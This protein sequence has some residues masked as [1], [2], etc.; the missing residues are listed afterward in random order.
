MAPKN[1]GAGSAID[2]TKAWTTTALFCYASGSSTDN[3]DCQTNNLY[4]GTTLV[5][6][7]STTASEAI[8]VG[9]V[10]TADIKARMVAGGELSSAYA[11]GLASAYAGVDGLTTGWFLPSKDEL[12]AMCYYS[13][14]LSASPDPTV[15]CFGSGG[16]TQDGTF[17]AGNFGFDSQK[18]WSSSQ[19][20]ATGAWGQFFSNGDRSNGSKASTL[21]V[22][23]VRAF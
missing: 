18:Y 15:N 19:G 20:S 21:R 2:P 13:R 14:N 10:N 7:A 11:A 3:A 22:R 6:S 23:P 12:N 4:P 17:A 9:S 5:Q 16:T 1:W 8:G